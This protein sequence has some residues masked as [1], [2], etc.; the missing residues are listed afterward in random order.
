AWLGCLVLMASMIII[1]LSATTDYYILTY[2]GYSLG[3]LRNTEMADATLASI[4]TEFSD[5]QKVV[6]DIDT[7]EVQKIKLGNI[8]LKCMDKDE[9]RET[10][11]MAAQTIEY[12][13]KVYIDD[14]YIMA[15]AGTQVFDNAMLDYKNDRITISEDINAK[16]D[17]CDIEILNKIDTKRVCML[18]ED[19]TTKGSYNGLYTAFEEKLQYRI[20]C[21]QTV[22]ESI[23]YMTYYT[24][25]DALAQG[26][27]RTVQK[28]QYGVKKVQSKVIVENGELVSSKVVKEKITKKS[29][30][31][32]LE[33]GNDTKGAVAGGI[34]LLFPIDGYLTSDF[35]NRPDPFTGQIAYHNG[36]DIGATTGTPIQAA[37]AGKVIQASDKK[38]GYGKCVII[39]HS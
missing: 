17:S 4:K 6:D 33:I 21:L 9:F 2:Q 15:V 8:F 16:Y 14:E 26:E 19:I 38:N 11:V 18:T 25:N 39:E 32:R 22:D 10:V 24:R 30:M 12:G 31:R 1:I 35:G 37:A 7:F 23:P 27:K 28:G 29:V 20:E 34:V 5:N 3:Y 13:Y 36:L